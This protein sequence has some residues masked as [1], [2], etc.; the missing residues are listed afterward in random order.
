NSDNRPSVID[1][2][3]RQTFFPTLFRYSEPY[4]PGSTI[5]NTNRFFD[6]NKD[7]YDRAYGQVVRMILWQRRLRIAQERKWGEV[8]VYSKFVK[9]NSG[10]SDLIVSDKIIEANNIEYFDQDFGIGNQPRG[11]AI[12]D[13]QIWFFD[14]VRGVICR[15]SLDGVKQISE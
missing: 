8:G 3:A 9:N 12:N 1:T 2:T 11:L 6:G 13:Y 7:F 4:V 10:S 15:L 14:P 5:N